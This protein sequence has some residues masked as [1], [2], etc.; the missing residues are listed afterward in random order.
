MNDTNSNIT[1]ASDS[2]SVPAK[3]PPSANEKPE[4]KKIK[5]E[6]QKAKSTPKQKGKL[7][8]LSHLYIDKEEFGTNIKTSYLQ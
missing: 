2:T 1:E 7:N 6:K 8:I 5:K 4:K 3:C